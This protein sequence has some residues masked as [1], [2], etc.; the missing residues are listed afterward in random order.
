MPTMPG[1]AGTTDAACPIKEVLIN[2]ALPWLG[3]LGG[4][5]GHSMTVL[6][7]LFVPSGSWF[8][9]VGRLLGRL[10]DPGRLL[11]LPFG[12]ERPGYPVV[13]ASVSRVWITDARGS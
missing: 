13:T 3:G 8:R 12:G 9:A 11:P 1:H 4:S 10:A 2:V 6:T 5:V 7:S